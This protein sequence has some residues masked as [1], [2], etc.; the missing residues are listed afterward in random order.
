MFRRARFVLLISTLLTSFCF[1]QVGV[2]STQHHDMSLTSQFSG[3]GASLQGTVLSALTSKPM[4]NARVELHDITNGTVMK[5]VYTN[6]G[7]QFDFGSIP[8]GIYRVVAVQGVA[9]VEERVD[10]SSMGTTV[11][12]RLPVNDAPAAGLSSN[13][14]SVAQYKVPEQARNEYMK[15]AQASE[16][17]KAPEALKHLARALEIYPDYADALTL[18]AILT[19]ASNTPAAIDDLQKAIQADGNYALAYTVLGSAFNS[20]DK[21]DQAIQTLQRAQ[22][23]APDAWQSYFEMARAYLG[24]AD[25]QSALGQLDKAQS[26]LPSEYAPLRLVKAQA[27]MALKQYDAAVAECR[28]Y[29]QKDPN[30]PNVAAAHKMMEQAQLLAK[31]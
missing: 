4:Q 23:L 14:V 1:A 26:L 22:S 20:Q 27:L 6:T 7:G 10:V 3:G 16:R 17:T 18:R 2:W 25:F 11:S 24:K 31:K 12:L 29:L 15:A 9:Q 28:T 13:T 8:Q 30:G 19:L 21:F 5:S